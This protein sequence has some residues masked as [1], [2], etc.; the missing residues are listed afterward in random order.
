MQQDAEFSGGCRASTH[1]HRPWLGH[2]KD[3]DNYS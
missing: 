2:K 3:Q 1:M